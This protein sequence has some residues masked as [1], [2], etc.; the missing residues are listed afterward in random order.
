LV[1]ESYDTNGFILLLFNKCPAIYNY[2]VSGYKHPILLWWTPFT[3]ENGILK[4]CDDHSVEAKCY[5]SN[6]RSY[7]TNKNLKV[8]IQHCPLTLTNN[9]VTPY[10]S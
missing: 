5:F 9:F 10:P 6:E 7:I 3:G 8:S 2:N 4:N 1:W